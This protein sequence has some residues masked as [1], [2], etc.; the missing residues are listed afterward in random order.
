MKT[1]FIIIY[2]ILLP[3]NDGGNGR[4]IDKNIENLLTS[5][6]LAKSKKPNLAKSKKLDLAKAKNLDFAKVHSFKT[7]FLTFKTKKTFI[8]L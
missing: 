1:R 5:K 8:Y 7:E 4:D 6:K 2:Q 3:G